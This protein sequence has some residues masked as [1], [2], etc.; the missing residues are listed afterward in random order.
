MGMVVVVLVSTVARGRGL[1]WGRGICFGIAAACL[2]CADHCLFGLLAGLL[3]KLWLWQ[4]TYRVSL[5][6]DWVAY[7]CCVAYFV[8]HTCVARL[9]ICVAPYAHPLDEDDVVLRPAC[10]HAACSDC[11][12]CVHPHMGPSFPAHAAMCRCTDSCQG[13]LQHILHRQPWCACGETPAPWHM[14]GPGV[15]FGA[16]PLMAGLGCACR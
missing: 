4:H 14:L 1:K 6:H 2:V 3:K 13:L 12:G 15:L 10:R 11:R 16:L 9:H 5:P 7:L 8:P